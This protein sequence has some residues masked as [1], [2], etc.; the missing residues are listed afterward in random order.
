M[1]KEVRPNDR[2]RS[3]DPREGRICFGNADHR[4]ND[5]LVMLRVPAQP[6]SLALHDLTHR[7][8]N[9]LYT[10]IAEEGRLQ[11]LCRGSKPEMS[12]IQ[13]SKLCVWRTTIVF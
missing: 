1:R 5:D 3:L 12:L 2:R 9:E 13:I 6:E 10:A 4:D 7:A 11:P 8:C